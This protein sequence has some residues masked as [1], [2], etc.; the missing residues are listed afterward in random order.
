MAAKDKDA[1]AD[2]TQAVQK[3][4]HE[5]VC[6]EIELH[7]RQLVTQILKPS[8]DKYALM[9]SELEIQ[10][11]KIASYAEAFADVLVM[12]GHL[13]EVREMTSILRD[14]LEQRDNDNRNFQSSCQTKFSD[15]NSELRD[16]RFQLDQKGSKIQ[17]LQ[18]EVERKGVEIKQIQTLQE[19]TRRDIDSQVEEIKERHNKTEQELTQQMNA[20]DAGQQNFQEVLWGDDQGLR[21]VDAQISAINKSISILPDLQAAL[22]Q[23][24]KRQGAVEDKMTHAQ[25]WLKKAQQDM[26]ELE[27]TFTRQTKDVK[28]KMRESS[29]QYA[30]THAAMMA[31]L[32]QQHEHEYGQVR[33]LRT[34]VECFVKQSSDRVKTIES[35]VAKQTNAWESL[36]REFR[37]DLEEFNKKRKRDKLTMDLEFKEVKKYM[38]GTTQQFQPIWKTVDHFNGVIGILVEAF[39]VDVALNMQDYNDRRQ[40]SWL[41][42]PNDLHKPLKPYEGLKGLQAAKSSGQNSMSKEELVDLRKVTK[43]KR[44][45]YFPG[46]VLYGNTHYERPDLIQIMS[47]LLEKAGIALERGPSANG[48]NGRGQSRERVIPEGS[49]LLEET[50]ALSGKMSMFDTAMAEIPATDDSTDRPDSSKL[51]PYRGGSRGQARLS[52]ARPGSVG[53]PGAVGSR[54]RGDAVGG[55]DLPRIG[56][57]QAGSQGPPGVGGLDLPP[58]SNQAESGMQPAP[59]VPM[60]ARW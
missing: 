44:M 4:E 50:G 6:A 32:K 45:N 17:H 37:S 48:V 23:G 2:A 10:K 34:D 3:K 49:P 16:I 19:E 20:I 38:T 36:H 24:S 1:I 7:L 40:I 13:N 58:L 11:E 28:E 22:D 39:K 51:P 31:N 54:G 14:E 5:I 8:I 59:I 15:I 25:N 30:A 9:E 26:Q 52:G 57:A 41:G 55:L 35:D 47:K 33:K 56:S 53:Q 43:L 60:T 42:G 21:K 46:D 27:K 29:N 12:K 18:R